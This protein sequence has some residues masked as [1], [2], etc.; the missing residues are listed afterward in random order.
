MLGRDL[1]GEPDEER[2]VRQAIFRWVIFI[3]SVGAIGDAAIGGL[4]LASQ[5]SDW[6]FSL[7]MPLAWAFIGLITVGAAGAA[8]Y[9]YVGGLATN[10]EVTSSGVIFAFLARSE[11]FFWEDFRGTVVWHQ[12]SAT[13]TNRDG[14]TLTGSFG[15][16]NRVDFN[17]EAFWGNRV[18]SVTPQMAGVILES[19]RTQGWSV[20]AG[21]RLDLQMKSHGL[22]NTSSVVRGLGG[23]R[24]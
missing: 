7:P 19:P 20:P 4:W 21:I 23:N 12:R 14:F 5:T 15:M 13:T 24:L 22:A 1:K 8:A 6:L 17:L 18:V 11:A 2:A 10:V 9:P 16:P 3:A